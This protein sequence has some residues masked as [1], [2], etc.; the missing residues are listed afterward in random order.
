MGMPVAIVELQAGT[1]ER[2]NIQNAVAPLC[3]E[4]GQTHLGSGQIVRALNSQ[5]PQMQILIQEQVQIIQVKPIE[6]IRY[7]PFPILRRQL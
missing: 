4:V 7:L 1:G 3:L 6:L 5:R 2:G